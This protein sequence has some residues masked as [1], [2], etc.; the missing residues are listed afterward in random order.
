MLFYTRLHIIII[1]SRV[2]C[3][4]MRLNRCF[5]YLSITVITVRSYFFGAK[6]I[7]TTTYF[8]I[9][10]VYWTYYIHIHF[11]R[12]FN[13]PNFGSEFNYYYYYDQIL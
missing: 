1:R 8:S 11:C 5:S 9:L 12:C 10:L 3:F 2:I 13:S 7:F 6:H 4:P